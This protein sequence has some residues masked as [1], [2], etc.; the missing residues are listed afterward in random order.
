V[1]GAPGRRTPV[2]FM[3]RLLE[4]QVAVID[5]ALIRGAMTAEERRRLVVN[6]QIVL[7]TVL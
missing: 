6:V 1:K 3:R 5:S 2:P 7:Y 4:A